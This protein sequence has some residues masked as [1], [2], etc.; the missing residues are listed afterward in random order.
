MKQLIRQQHSPDS[1][2]SPGA[3]WVL[4]GVVLLTIL[5]GLILPTSA[6]AVA[7]SGSLEKG[8]YL[9]KPRPTPTSTPRPR[10]TTPASPTPTT[11]PPTATATMVPTVTA[12]PTQIP[13]ARTADPTTPAGTGPTGDSWLTTLGWGLGAAVLSIL[14]LG[15]F[16]LLVVRRTHPRL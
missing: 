8:S 10:P 2:L 13:T 1:H 14:A 6:V 5:F 4:G 12:L 3:R 11:Q 16:L 7:V 15:A 9:V